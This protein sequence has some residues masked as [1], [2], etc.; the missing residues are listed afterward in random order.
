MP[1]ASLLVAAVPPSGGVGLGIVILAVG[2]LMAGG[3]AISLR[4]IWAR[5]RAEEPVARQ[6]P[7]Q[8]GSR[9]LRSPGVGELSGWFRMLVSFDFGC[10]ALVSVVL[11][12]AGLAVI[13]RSL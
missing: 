3:A 5:A 9:P 1:L 12:F 13:F 6:G 11:I 8:E 2:L 10:L 4:S 7:I